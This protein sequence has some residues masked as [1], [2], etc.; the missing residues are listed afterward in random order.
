MEWPRRICVT[1]RDPV[2]GQCLFSVRNVHAAKLSLTICPHVSPTWQGLSYTKLGRGIATWFLIFL[3]R[4]I[5]KMLRQ[6][7]PLRT[8]I[9]WCSSMRDDGRR[10]RNLSLKEHLWT[11]GCSWFLIPPTEFVSCP[12]SGLSS[13]QHIFYFTN[14]KSAPHLNSEVTCGLQLHLLRFLFLIGFRERAIRPNDHPSPTSTLQSLARQ[15]AVVLLALFYRH[16]FGFCSTE[17]AS[18]DPLPA[19][20]H[21]S[22]AGFLGECPYF[23][24]IQCLCAKGLPR[25]VFYFMFGENRWRPVLY[26]HWQ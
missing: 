5:S 20:F 21:F 10:I 17:L 16:L 14:P 25:T 13:P 9:K 22:K 8:G 1:T 2:S 26:M 19:T 7:N 6:T 11:V 23:P 4:I 24:P 18:V 3:I 12:E 15:P